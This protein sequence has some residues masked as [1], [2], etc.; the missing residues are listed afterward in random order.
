MQSLQRNTL[1]I[2]YSTMADLLVIAIKISEILCEQRANQS[3]SKLVP[4]LNPLES[5]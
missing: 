5:W 1:F 3:A 2:Y 4:V